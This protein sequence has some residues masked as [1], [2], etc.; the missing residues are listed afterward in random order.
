MAKQCDEVPRLMGEDAVSGDR[1][2]EAAGPGESV[3]LPLSLV[4][5]LVHTTE[6]LELEVL[7]R[8]LVRRHAIAVKNS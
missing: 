8:R 3:Q 1:A 2:L 6:K 5:S 7:N 4:L